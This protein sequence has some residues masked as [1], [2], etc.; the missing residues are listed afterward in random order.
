MKLRLPIPGLEVGKSAGLIQVGPVLP[1]E[2][3]T[4][5]GTQ[6]GKSEVEECPQKQSES[7]CAAGFDYGGR[8]HKIRHVG[9]LWKQEKDKEMDS[10]L[11]PPEGM[12][13]ASPFLIAQ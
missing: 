13:P 3:S 7:C 1:P 11:E 4:V 5:A 8:G 6:K 9:G 10:S 12:Q 2:A